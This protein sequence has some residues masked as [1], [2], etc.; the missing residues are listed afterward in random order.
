MAAESQKVLA[1]VA[2]NLLL[3]FVVLISLVFVVRD[4]F[5]PTTDLSKSLVFLVLLVGLLFVGIGFLVRL[6][7][8]MQK[9]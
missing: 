8:S 9:D 4:L 7:R 6:I 2:F 3:I 5:F 1:Q